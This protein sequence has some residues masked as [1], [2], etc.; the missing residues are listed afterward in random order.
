MY[1]IFFL[2]IVSFGSLY[3]IAQDGIINGKDDAAFAEELARWGYSDLAEEMANRIA[4]ANWLPEEQR[5]AGQVLRCSLI[6]IRGER[7]TDPQEQS[8]WYQE[9]ISGYRNLIP[10]MQGLAQIKLK[11][12]MG[13]TLVK[14]VRM[15]LDMQENKLALNPSSSSAEANASTSNF[16][17]NELLAQL[18]EAA[19]LFSDI[20]LATDKAGVELTAQDNT[21]EEQRRLELANLRYQGVF[22]YCRAL[23]FQIKLGKI[24]QAQPCL[25]ELDKYIWDY[26]GLVG[27]YY[28]I[29][30]R[31][32]VFHEQKKY[33]EA[34]VC[35]D[36]VIK[37]L[38][39]NY[40]FNFEEDAIEFRGDVVPNKLRD[41]FQNNK[42]IELSDKA[43]VQSLGKGAGWVIRDQ[44]NGYWIK[45][46]MNAWSVYQILRNNTALSLRIQAC[47]YKAKTLLA[48]ERY[49]Q[50][51]LTVS[52]F[53]SNLQLLHEKALV[54]E[55]FGQA[56]MLE[57]AKAYIG[58]NEN[59]KALEIAQKVAE[60]PGLW[61]MA[62][63]RSLEQWGR[64]D[65][66]A[67]QSPKAAYLVATGFWEKNRYTDAMVGYL[68]VIQYSTS[69]DDIERFAI[70]AFDKLGQCFWQLKMYRESGLCYQVLAQDYRQY[71]KIA[72]V[73]TKDGP[74][75][76]KNS[77][78]DKAAYW[79]YRGYNESFRNDGDAEEQKAAQDMLAYLI[80]N[81]PDSGYALNRTYDQARDKEAE[82]DALPNSEKAIAKLLEA[83]NL[84]KTVKPNADQYEPAWVYAGKC[85]FKAAETQIQLDNPKTTSSDAPTTTEKPENPTTTDSPKTPA[86]TSTP[87]IQITA[88][89]KEY[90]QLA[91]QE[92][93]AYQKYTE[94]TAI[95]SVDAQRLARRQDS[96]SFATYYQGRIA[97]L[98]SDNKNAI[99]YFNKIR[100]QYAEQVDMASAATYFL[101]KLQIEQGNLPAAEQLLTDFESKLKEPPDSN[102][103]LGRYQ[104]HSHYLLGMEYDKQITA[105]RA[106]MPPPEDK[107]KQVEWET[108]W[109]AVATKSAGHLSKWIEIRPPKQSNTYDWIASKLI[110]VAQ[111]LYERG[112]TTEAA[113]YY[114]KAM[115]LFTKAIEAQPDKEKQ[116]IAKI[117]LIRCTII[118]GDWE[119]A[120]KIMY[121][122][123]HKDKDE[124]EAQRQ[125]ERGPRR[126][127]KPTT[128]KQD[129]AY[130][131]LM[132]EILMNLGEKENFNNERE[133]YTFLLQNGRRDFLDEF[134]DFREMNPSATSIY[135]KYLNFMKLSSW[136]NCEVFSDAAQKV[137]NDA[138]QKDKRRHTGIQASKLVG[139][140]DRKYREAVDAEFPEDPTE[141][142]S[143][144]SSDQIK[145]HVRR[146]SIYLADNFTVL[147]VEKLP[148]YQNLQAR[149]GAYDNPQWWEAKYRQIYLTYLR[150]EPKLACSAI[151]ILRMQQKTMG[152]PKFAPKF[153]ALYEKAQ[154][155]QKK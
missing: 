73:N 23:Y 52:E 58:Q 19:M 10:K 117:K 108:R 47:Y 153:Q 67:L 150:G 110:D 39:E 133:L 79:A 128:Q 88:K 56:A 9:A 147:L 62:A 84:Y 11:L 154:A 49:D 149:F 137:L 145:E 69:K 27:G 14:Q 114:Q 86:P 1:K 106:S 89:A 126:I 31:G 41:M 2:F 37:A 42:K 76:E 116:Q 43:K 63:K 15:I 33:P 134:N 6:Q 100:Q 26:E 40:L 28:A 50:A 59:A 17:Q 78:A 85:Y 70:D 94:T 5:Q 4:Q 24:E 95:A 3:V 21:P 83:A 18:K 113:T 64:M 151:E 120:I 124:R 93:S 75:E 136:F 98:L 146:L 44:D 45:K 48:G 127:G 138:W 107:K 115:P 141:R 51:V 122:I 139:L 104:S 12:E 35:F 142:I 148:E 7:A 105:L 72:Q 68:K 60:K 90:L 22:G 57:L 123:Y 112:Q 155:A 66:N 87:A 74:K 125:I 97:L 81:W 36:S 20:K 61:G 129:A 82:A 65:P 140:Y 55:W 131:D 109:L 54:D 103:T 144:L 32:M 152:G 102:S 132:S 130:L 34:V 71:Q 46:E 80:K 119:Q 121:P 53:D 29:L 38:A 25:K 99:L 16:N 92:L 143:K 8:R 91:A 118:V 30:L 111:K 101:I 96:L 13:E 135:E 77:I